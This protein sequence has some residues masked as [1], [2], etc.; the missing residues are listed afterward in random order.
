MTLEKIPAEK[1]LELAD[2][3]PVC[4]V[5]SPSEYNSGHI[6]GAINIPLFDD[7]EREAVG[8]KYKK[9]GRIPA[10]LEG[11][12]LSSPMMS[13]KLSQALSTAKNGKLLVHCWRGGMRSEAMAW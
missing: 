9:E 10:I 11:L 2:S 8:I 13:D 4:D 12:K 3:I 5:R 1:F 6:P 7:I